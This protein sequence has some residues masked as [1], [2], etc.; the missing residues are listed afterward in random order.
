MRRWVVIAI[1][2]FL[3]GVAGCQSEI[4]F[5]S[6]VLNEESDSIDTITMTRTAIVLPSITPTG[7]STPTRV[8]TRYQQPTQ[9]EKK[10]F[11]DLGIS[12]LLPAKLYD[13]F[14]N[15]QSNS[16]GVHCWSWPVD[17]R[18]IQDYK[19]KLCV[20]Y[21]DTELGLSEFI[22][23]FQSAIKKGYPSAESFT[24]ED[25]ITNGGIYG[26]K[27]TYTYTGKDNAA[28]FCSFYFFQHEWRGVLQFGFCRDDAWRRTF[29]Q[30]EYVDDYLEQAIK[31]LQWTFTQEF[32]KNN[33][34]E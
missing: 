23:W 15:H 16:P 19:G 4:A 17:V 25:F 8:P 30:G 27:V 31:T 33:T 5:R 22:P 24:D 26:R 11:L 12:F 3:F 32:T 1:L 14:G 28:Y 20:E 10:Y 29:E 21:P 2:I 7:T 9:H 6:P 34:E 13:G 18:R